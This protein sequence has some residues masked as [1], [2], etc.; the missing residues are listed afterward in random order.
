MLETIQHQRFN[1][2]SLDKFVKEERDH[3][4]LF[5]RAN[6]EQEQRLL[7]NVI[8]GLHD[9][10]ELMLELH[11]ELMAA[12]PCFYRR[13]RDESQNPDHQ[14]VFREDVMEAVE[15]D[16]MEAN[17]TAVDFFV[18]PTFVRVG[19]SNGLHFEGETVIAKAKV[20]CLQGASITNA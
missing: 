9:V 15:V 4:L 18:S 1:E 3:L 20:I 19:R 10:V 8:L 2:D 12:Q 11:D 6:E 14:Q 13:W 16:G 17:S 7:D 5:M